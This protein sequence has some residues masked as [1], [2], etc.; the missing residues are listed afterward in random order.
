MTGLD[1]KVAEYVF[2]SV[3]TRNF[4]TKLADLLDFLIPLYTEEGKLSLT[5]GVGCTGGR[6]RSV[7]IAAALTEYLKAKGVSAVNAN[8]DINK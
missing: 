5:V 6:H 7:A 3:Q 1:R 2:R 8:R 4:M